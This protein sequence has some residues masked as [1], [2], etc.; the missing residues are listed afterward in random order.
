MWMN[1]TEDMILDT[2][3]YEIIADDQFTNIIHNEIIDI[4]LLE[5]LN[6]DTPIGVKLI[7]KNDY[8]LSTPIADGNTIESTQFNKNNNLDNFLNFREIKYNSIKG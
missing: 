4:E 5:I 2:E 7:L 3:Y 6:N 1:C 8:I